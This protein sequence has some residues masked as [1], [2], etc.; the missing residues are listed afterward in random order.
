MLSSFKQVAHLLFVLEADLKSMI[1]IHLNHVYQPLDS[2]GKMYI[3]V[4]L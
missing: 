2:I 3:L 1:L 4:N